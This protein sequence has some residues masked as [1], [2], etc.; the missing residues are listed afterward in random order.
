MHNVVKDILKQKV[1]IPTKERELQSLKED[2]EIAEKILSGE[3]IYCENCD[4]YF[5]SKSFFTEEETKEEEICI[6]NDPIN[7]SGNEYKNGKVKY[8]YKICPKGH[9]HIIYKEGV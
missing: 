3:F 4:D 8:I 5:L 1:K 6:Y 7:S 2:I 9:K